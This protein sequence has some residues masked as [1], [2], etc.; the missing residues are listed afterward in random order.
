MD[1][2]LV[3][4]SKGVLTFYMQEELSGSI[5]KRGPNPECNVVFIMFL[6]LEVK[7]DFNSNMS[8]LISSRTT[9]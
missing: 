9:Q 4:F 8:R 1:F 6:L 7:E 5:D 2:D 3:E